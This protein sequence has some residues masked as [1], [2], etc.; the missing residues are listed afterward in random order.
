M[1]LDERNF[2]H[3]LGLHGGL[4]DRRVAL[5]GGGRHRPAVRLHGRRPPAVRQWLLRDAHRRR[6]PV[7]G[8]GHNQRAAVVLE[9]SDR[10]FGGAAVGESCAPLRRGERPRRLRRL[11]PSRPI[12]R[13]LHT[14]S[15]RGARLL[16]HRHAHLADGHELVVR[17][18]AQRLHYFTHEFQLQQ[19]HL[20]IDS[21]HFLLIYNIIDIHPVIVKFIYEIVTGKYTF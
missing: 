11:A 21:R 2:V 4:N 10:L 19:Q 1:R 17:C 6:G 3:R 13:V 14:Q 9:R 5:V 20:S 8:G 12:E 18:G 15:V 16:G 7:R